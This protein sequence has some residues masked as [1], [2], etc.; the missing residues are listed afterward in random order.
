MLRVLFWCAVTVAAIALAVW[1]ACAMR[2]VRRARAALHYLRYQHVS[3]RL[4]SWIDDAFPLD[5]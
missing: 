4:R 3:P 1:G 2:R 5:T